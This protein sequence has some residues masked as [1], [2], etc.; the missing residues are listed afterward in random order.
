LAYSSGSIEITTTAVPASDWQFASEL[1]SA[2]ADESGSNPDPG[3]GQPSS[4]PSH[5]QTSESAPPQLRLL[6]AEDNLPDAL[7]V[8]QAIQ[9][10]NLPLEVYTVA[11][12]EQAL[13]FI[14]RAEKDHTAPTLHAMILDLNLPKIDG[15]EIL[16]RIR[17]SE[18]YK[19]VPVLIVTSSDSPADRSEGAS[20]GASYFRKPA[21]YAEF[22]KIGA[23]LKRFLEENGLLI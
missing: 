11:D 15:F 19:N 12:G 5:S 1:L 8:R 3:K 22:L 20:L 2:M 4:S 23:T 21:A 14:E 13:E 18:K 9:N 10:E 16:R 6:L 17:A 7:L